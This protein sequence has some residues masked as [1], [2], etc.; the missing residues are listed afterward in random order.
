MENTICKDRKPFIYDGTFEG[1]LHGGHRFL[2]KNGAMMPDKEFRIYAGI[3]PD[4]R[5]MGQDVEMRKYSG[6]V[7]VEPCVFGIELESW[8]KACDFW[9][10]YVEKALRMARKLHGE[11]KRDDGS[12]YL[13]QHIYPVTLTILKTIR[14]R[15][16]HRSPVITPQD[17]IIAALLHDALEDTDVKEIKIIDEFG[18]NVYEMIKVLTKKRPWEKNYSMEDYI[19]RLNSSDFRIRMIKLADRMNNLFCLQYTTEEK[20]KWYIDD[21]IKYYLPLAK[22]TSRYFYIWMKRVLKSMNAL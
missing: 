4:P 3:G 7:Y 6:L 17:M 1:W 11:Q 20:R 10:P 15:H 2:L 5:E 8:L 19:K 21:T 14:L 13:E 16:I 18:E 9:N 12:P 22:N